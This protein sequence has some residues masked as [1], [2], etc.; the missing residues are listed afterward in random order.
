MIGSITGKKS[1]L[2]KMT[3]DHANEEKNLFT[4]WRFLNKQIVWGK[5]F[6]PTNKISINTVYYKT[7]KLAVNEIE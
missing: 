6:H 5:N 1:G 7:S 4:I 2:Y 3:Y